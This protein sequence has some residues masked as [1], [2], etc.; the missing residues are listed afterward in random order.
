MKDAL[1]TRMKN[2]FESRTKTKL[3]RKCPVVLRLD[4]KTFST[5]TKGFKR[6]F[7]EDLIDMMN[8]TALFLCKEIQGAKMAY[9]QSDEISILVTD[10]DKEDTQAWF[11]YSGQKMTSVSA[12]FATSEFN[13]ELLK[14]YIKKES[15]DSE[16]IEKMIDGSV[17]FANFDSRA[18]SVPREVDLIDYFV[19][20]MKD[21]EK[22]SIS[23]LAQS[24][25]SH[26]TLDGV[27]GRDKIEMCK[28]RGT[29]W[30]E[31][32]SSQRLGRIISRKT[33]WKETEHRIKD[34]K[35][36]EGTAKTEDGI[37]YVLRKVW[38]VEEETVPFWK[39]NDMISSVLS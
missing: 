37:N 11:D 15:S 18:F 38:K 32:P 10:F 8:K 14:Y 5:F 19:W 27:S 21:A 20:R 22:N 9:V 17:K 34:E 3:I 39:E 33:E 23:M 7:D 30:N 13:K 28:D 24:M 31:L 25:F 6:P 16:L 29:D 4:G 2:F 36:D 1:G 26:K 35:F 12:S